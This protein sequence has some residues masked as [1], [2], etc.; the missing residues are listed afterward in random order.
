MPC[1]NK[2]KSGTLDCSSQSWHDPPQRTVDDAATGGVG[3]LN[4]QLEPYLDR[5]WLTV[6]GTCASQLEMHGHH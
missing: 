1:R 5:V 6:A 2:G 3:I 4:L